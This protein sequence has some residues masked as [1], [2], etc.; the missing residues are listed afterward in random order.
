MPAV[1]EIIAPLYTVMP[2]TDSS[3]YLETLFSPDPNIHLDVFL[4]FSG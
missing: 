1:L 3:N 2:L 4:F